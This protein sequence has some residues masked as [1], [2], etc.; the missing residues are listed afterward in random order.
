MAVQSTLTAPIAELACRRIM[1]RLMP[2]LFVLYIIAYLDR[3]NVGYAFL[4]LKGD[5]GFT[6]TVLGFGAGVFFIGYFILEIPGSLL[7]EKWSARGWIARI[8][9]TWGIV[10]ILLGIIQTKNQFYG[11]R[12]LLGAAEAGF[13]P[14]IIVYLSHWFRYADRAKA[15]AVFVAAQPIS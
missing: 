6:D 10:A 14:G 13:F 2:Y 15:L 11:L 9:I 1:R 4:Q 7:V 12:F 8:M 5:L 3:V